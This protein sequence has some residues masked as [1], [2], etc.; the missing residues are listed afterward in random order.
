MAKKNQSA[1]VQIKDGMFFAQDFTKLHKRHVIYITKGL[2]ID[3][4][5][6]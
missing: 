5:K 2:I 4:D 3:L 6:L 1:G